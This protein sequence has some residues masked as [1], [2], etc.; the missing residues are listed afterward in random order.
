MREELLKEA[1]RKGI[2]VRYEKRFIRAEEMKDGGGLKVYFEDGHV[3]DT[4]MVIGADGL[5]SSVRKFVDAECEPKYSGTMVL[6]GMVSRSLLDQRLSSEDQRLPNPTMLFGRE[7][8]FTV[9]PYDY[10]GEKVG[11]IA[12]IELP[13]RSKEEWRRFGE[14]AEGLRDLLKEKFCGG[15]WPEQVQIMCQ[16]TSADEFK[17]WP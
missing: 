6:Y 9:W 8:S 7:G 3:V 12:N 13:E 5:R 11:Y 10:E 16:E 4:E 14:N 15:G 2:E 1:E 17:I